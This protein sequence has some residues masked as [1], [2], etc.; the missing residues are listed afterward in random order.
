LL[1]KSFF[2]NLNDIQ[3]GGAWGHRLIY[4]RN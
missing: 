3:S 1:I 4:W 2:L